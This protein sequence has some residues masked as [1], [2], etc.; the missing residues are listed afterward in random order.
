MDINLNGYSVYEMQRSAI[1]ILN[2]KFNEVKKY[3]ADSSSS[4]N[5]LFSEIKVLSVLLNSFY[6]V[7]LLSDDELSFYSDWLSSYF[8]ALR[9]FS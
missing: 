5:F 9:F 8:R 4:Y 2:D 1:S 6:A 7:H 3:F